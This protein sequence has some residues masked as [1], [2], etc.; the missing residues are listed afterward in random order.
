V[1]DGDPAGRHRPA[2][3][4][5]E[6]PLMEI[7]APKATIRRRTLD[8]LLT[9]GIGLLGM[10]ASFAVGSRLFSVVAGVMGALFVG[11]VGRRLWPNTAE[12]PDGREWLR[13]VGAVVVPCGIVFGAGLF[14]VMGERDL[15]GS[16]CLSFAVG[17]L[18]SAV[19]DARVVRK[20]VSK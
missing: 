6:A 20:Q 12:T 1:V 17:L 13:F 9:L 10:V 4:L 3:Y 11:F 2:D 16:Y 19:L 14:L 8:V 18:V 15:A 5:A 7:F